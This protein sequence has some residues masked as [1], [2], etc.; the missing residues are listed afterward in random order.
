[1]E[2]DL[3][4]KWMNHERAVPVVGI[5]L[6]TVVALSVGLALV[7]AK[8]SDFDFAAEFLTTE[9]IVCALC[10]IA[11]ITL[12]SARRIGLRVPTPPSGWRSVAPMALVVVVAGVTWVLAR[13]SIDASAQIDAAVS[14]KTLA[15][16]AAVGFA[17]EWVYRG[18]LLVA[19]MVWLGPKL[20]MWVSMVVF[21]LF[22]VINLIGG[23]SPGAVAAQVVLTALAAAPLTLLALGTRSL[24]PA[25]VGHWLYD[26]F[27]I[28]AAQLDELG[29]SQ[30]PRAIVPVVAIAAAVFSIRE[31]A[32]FEVDEP[33]QPQA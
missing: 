16:T 7:D 2:N 6:T 21:G 31:L 22:H 18:L 27:V 15:T 17:E 30:G 24:I 29:A 12:F 26:F 14:L 4:Q 10:V 3:K 9:L 25:M 13:Q 33:Y 32:R 19:L 11:S 5:W 28:D 20:G 8:Y 1:M 23:A